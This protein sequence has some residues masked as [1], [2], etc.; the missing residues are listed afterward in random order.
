MALSACAPPNIAVVR[1][2]PAKRPPASTP[3]LAPTAG[4]AQETVRPSPTSGSSPGSTVPAT[5]DVT[6]SPSLSAVTPAS[7]ATVGSAV[8][9]DKRALSWYYVRKG[10]GL[11]PAF[12]ADTKQFGPDRKAI[13]IGKG[14]TVYLT[15]DNGGDMNDPDR[16][17]DV[18]RENG[19]KA[20]FFIAGYNLKK[21]PDFVRR[22]VA[23]GHLVANHSMTHRDF[24]AMTDAQ[25]VAEIEEYA[26]LYRDITGQEIKPY[27]RFPYGKYSLHLL[28]V[29][30]ELGYTS[31]FWSLAMRDWEPRA[32]GWKDAY[33]D[34]MSQ[35]HDGCVILMHQGSKDNLEALDR[36]LKDVRAAGYTFGLVSNI[37]AP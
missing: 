4:G 7:S 19:V 14:K 28:D 17:L 10:R 8:Y 16:W 21:H 18:L 30:S 35:L 31:V 3:S 13:W 27:F 32:G 25:A 37:G 22:L 33:N 5:P 15:I 20:S 12:P 26:R 34:I 11:A 2:S 29:V 24:T 9:G 36:V 6:G 23:E 1:E